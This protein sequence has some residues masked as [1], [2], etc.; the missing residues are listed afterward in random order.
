MESNLANVEAMGDQNDSEKNENFFYL[1]K[2]CCK[3]CG[4][5]LI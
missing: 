5:K 2:N 3:F 4:E 1:S